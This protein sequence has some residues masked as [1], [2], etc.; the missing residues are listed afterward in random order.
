M[1]LE[2]D[3]LLAADPGLGERLAGLP[4]RVFSGKRHPAIIWITGGDC[5]SIGS[6]WTEGPPGNEQTASA[7]R[8]AGIVMMFVVMLWK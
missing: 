2:Y 4:G 7:Y 5:N 1:Q 6:V 3:A 8:K